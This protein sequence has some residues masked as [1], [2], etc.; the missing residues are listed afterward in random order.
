VRTVKLLVQYDGTGYV[1]WQRQAAGVSIQGLLE[2]ALSRID[3]QAVVVHGAGR[4]DAGVHAHG[5]VAH[6]R[7]SAP[8]DDATMVRAINANLPDAVRVLHVGTVSDAFHARF[9]AVSKTYEYR[10]WNGGVVP[11]FLR[12]YVWQ[13]PQ[14]LDVAAMGRAAHRLVG[15]HDFAAFRGVGTPVHSTV[16]RVIAADWH[17]Q[18]ADA[19]LTFTITGT[20]FLRHMVRAVVG[21]LVEIGRGGRAEEDIDRLLAT[22][23]RHDA[24]QTAPAHGLVLKCVDYGSQAGTVAP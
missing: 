9:D 2:D 17:L 14:P 20:G 22:R 13:V 3:G 16:R 15:E 4:T 6:A 23:D 7:I 24:G 1:G 5:Q 10:I 18:G 21:T 12:L 11:P 19:P 8:H